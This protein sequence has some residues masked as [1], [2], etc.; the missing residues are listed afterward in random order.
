MASLRAC[1]GELEKADS[2][3]LPAHVI[4]RFGEVPENSP[5]ELSGRGSSLVVADLGP[6]VN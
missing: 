2:G 4:F 3:L 5:G 1:S 6:R